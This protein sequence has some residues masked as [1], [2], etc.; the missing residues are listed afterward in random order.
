[1]ATDKYAVEQMINLGLGTVRILQ[2]LKGVYLLRKK[3]IKPKY[4]ISNKKGHLM[5]KFNTKKI[6]VPFMRYI[7]L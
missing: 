7:G 6:G 1:M 3:I 2:Y 4:H 5:F